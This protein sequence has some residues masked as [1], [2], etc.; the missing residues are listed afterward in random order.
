MQGDDLLVIEGLKNPI[1]ASNFIEVLKNITRV[2]WFKDQSA[3][4][5]NQKSVEFTQTFSVSG[6]CFTFNLEKFDEIFRR[7]E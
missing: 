1:D 7:S 3:S 5:N 4:W 6:S 2:E